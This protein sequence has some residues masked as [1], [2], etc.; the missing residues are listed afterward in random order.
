MLDDASE[1][2]E[3]RI[4]PSIERVGVLPRRAGGDATARFGVL[5][6]FAGVLTAGRFRS[7]GR[8]RVDLSY[9]SLE[10][11]VV[12]GLASGGG[13]TARAPGTGSGADGSGGTDADATES[14]RGDD[15]RGRLTVREYLRRERDAARGADDDADR[16]TTDRSVSPA[17]R[18]N[19]GGDEDRTLSG[20]ES[21]SRDG[22]APTREESRT[23]VER[24]RR[25]PSEGDVD[26]DVDRGPDSRRRGGGDRAVHSGVSGERATDSAE[27]PPGRP[28]RRRQPPGG[29]V[30]R[31]DGAPGPTSSDGP[32]TVVG[33][34]PPAAEKAEPGAERER[35]PLVVRET[36]TVD[37]SESDGREAT[38]R[39][40]RRAAD[41]PPGGGE[42]TPAAPRVGSRA[43]GADD[44]AE[45][46]DGSGGGSPLAFDSF[47][48]PAF[49]RFV[50]RLSRRLDR[51]QRIERERRGL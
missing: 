23:V 25:P 27:P 7:T 2:S 42:Q 20:S 13:V 16:G 8:P 18:R 14:R 40:G 15:E 49:D 26:V 45:R 37:Q 35:P 38:A 48:D 10:P 12:A 50:E 47:S 46:V 41:A 21:P 5:R 4:R 39:D 51:K 19:A 30:E 9:L 29:D 44:G 6:P 34:S 31:R 24:W 43:T 3:I 1:Q 36:G 28:G 33:E 32:P 22:L 11:L 17:S